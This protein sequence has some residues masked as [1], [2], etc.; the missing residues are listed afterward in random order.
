MILSREIESFLV[1]ARYHSLHAASE[2][3]FITAAALSLQMKKL[4]YQVGVPLLVH[5]SKGTTLTPAGTLFAE[6]MK[7]AKKLEMEAL[8]LARR[9]GGRSDRDSS[10]GET[11]TAISPY[12]K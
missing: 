9:A 1:V 4:E 7:K 2:H 6:K 3:L 12:E 5:S 11:G 10:P 8:L